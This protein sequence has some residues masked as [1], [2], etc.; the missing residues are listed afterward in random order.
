MHVAH[1]GRFGQR[2]EQRELLAG[3]ST[4]AKPKLLDRLAEALRSRHYSRRTEQRM[5]G[6]T[7]AHLSVR[8]LARPK[9]R[10]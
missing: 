3:V 8:P 10:E 1:G 2:S 5:R 9:E 4:S 6:K 7:A